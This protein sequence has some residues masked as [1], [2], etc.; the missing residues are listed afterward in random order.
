MALLKYFSV[1]LPCL[2]NAEQRHEI[3]CGMWPT[4]TSSDLHTAMACLSYTLSLSHL[5]CQH[6]PI[7]RIHIFW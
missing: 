4:M 5:Q 6:S 7:T 3:F 1:V 2:M